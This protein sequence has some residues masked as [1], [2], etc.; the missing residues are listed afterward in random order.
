MRYG[1]HRV[2]YIHLAEGKQSE[3]F[4]MIETFDFPYHTYI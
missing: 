1:G 4:L 2:Y 3:E